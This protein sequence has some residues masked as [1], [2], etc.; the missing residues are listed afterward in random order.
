MPALGQQ[1]PYGTVR[2]PAGQDGGLAGAPLPPY[3]AARYLAGG[4]EPLLV[5]DGQGQKVPP[6]PG[7]PVETHRHQHD[8]LAIADGYGGVGLL[9]QLAGFDN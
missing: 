4:V 9:G 2:L 3:K 7:L 6:L 5:V 1:R 8:G